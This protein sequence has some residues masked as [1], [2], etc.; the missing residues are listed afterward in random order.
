MVGAIS[1]IYARLNQI[2]ARA[3]QRRKTLGSSEVVAQFAA[4][5]SLYGQSIT[6]ALGLSTTPERADEQLARLMVGLEELEG[7]FGEHEQFL[8]DILAKR[9]EMLEVFEAHKQ[10]LLDERQRKAQAVQDAATR[11]LAGLPRRTERLKSPD[12][13]NAFFAGDPLILK[14]RELAARLRELKDAV[15]ADDVEA[16]LKAVRDQ[17]VRA[18]GTDTNCSRTVG[19]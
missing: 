18:C 17:A 19:L 1:G 5:F 11:I 2:R 3:E 14:L 4:Q 9:E 12:E 16:R 15:K 7:Q 8:N 13:L 6:G 10:A